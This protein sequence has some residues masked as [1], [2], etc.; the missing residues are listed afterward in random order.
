M[1]EIDRRCIEDFGLAGEVLMETAGRSVA[2]HLLGICPGQRVAFLCGPGN[3]G[4]DGYVAARAWCDAGGVAEI[5]ALGESN[6]DEARANA[7][8]ARRWGISIQPCQGPPPSWSDY[9]Q[10]VD[11]LFGIGQRRNLEGSVSDWVGSLPR[12]R[13]L[14]VDIPSGIHSDTG[15]V[16]GR[17]VRAHTTITFGLAKLGQLLQPGATYCGQLLVQPIGF[18]EAL[19]QTP[20]HRVQTALARQ[21]LPARGPESHKRNMGKLLLLA[22][23]QRYPGAAILAALGALRAGVGLLY[24]CAPPQV[25]ERLPA[26]AIPV[27]PQDLDTALASVDAVCAGPGLDDQSHLLESLWKIDLPMVLDADALGHLPARLSPKVLL[28]PHHGELARLSRLRLPQIEQDRLQAA[29]RVARNFHCT[30]LLKGD[31]TLV[32]SPGGTYSVVSEGSAVLAQGGSGDVL[33]GVAGALIAQGLDAWQAGSLAAYLQGRAG[34][35][36]GLSVGLG[37]TR[38]ADHISMVWSQLYGS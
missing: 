22:G 23:S 19:L 12:E 24:V 33:A 25:L 17:A 16:L 35:L 3:N 18:P 32:T 5:F 2:Q 14:A 11:A 21:W 20:G 28:T 26:E 7:E 34:Q 15:Q 36:S 27:L 10:V 37:A 30:V 38:L 31:P 29:L 1:A 13:T 9:A 6:R 8:R 4:G